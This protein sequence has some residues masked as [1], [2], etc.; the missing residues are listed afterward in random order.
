MKFDLLS[1]IIGFLVAV[2]LF[3]IRTRMTSRYDVPAF[4]GKSQ[5]EL[6]SL[7]DYELNKLSAD[8]M[9]KME[10]SAPEEHEM[11]NADF[12]ASQKTLTDAYSAAMMAMAPVTKAD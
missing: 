2:V 3:L 11:I 4:T 6:Q 10:T 1:A 12:A 8:M 9:Q 5:M 7:Y